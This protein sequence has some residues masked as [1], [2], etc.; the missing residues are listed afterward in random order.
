MLD[1]TVLQQEQEERDFYFAAKDTKYIPIL[2]SIEILYF[3]A[4]PFKSEILIHH[5]TQSHY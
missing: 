3:L 1:S 5:M 4:I 2:Y